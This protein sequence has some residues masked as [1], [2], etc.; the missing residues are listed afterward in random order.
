MD[1]KYFR[2]LYKLQMWYLS[3]KYTY[4]LTLNRAWSQVGKIWTNVNTL[5]SQHYKCHQTQLLQEC[6]S[7]F[8][9]RFLELIIQAAAIVEPQNSDQEI[10]PTA[11]HI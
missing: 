11:D 2:H 9:W 4:G 10:F 6:N 1:S 5:L 3:Y 7:F 8:H